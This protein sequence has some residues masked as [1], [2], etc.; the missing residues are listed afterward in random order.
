MGLASDSSWWVRL[1]TAS[2]ALPAVCESGSDNCKEMLPA[3]SALCRDETVGVVNAALSSS[4]PWV[5][6]QGFFE[7][8]RPMLLEIINDLAHPTYSIT[9]STALHRCED[10]VQVQINAE[11]QRQQ[12]KV[13]ERSARLKKEA[14]ES[15]EHASKVAE[16]KATRLADAAER[17]ENESKAAAAIAQAEKA[18]ATKAKA[19][20]EE[21]KS[22]SSKARARAQKHAEAAARAK[23]SSNEAEAVAEKAMLKAKIAEHEMMLQLDEAAKAQ[24]SLNKAELDN[25]KQTLE[26]T[27]TKLANLETKLWDGFLTFGAAALPLLAS[28]AY[29]AWK[30]YSTS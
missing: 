8:I 7:E 9:A 26:M 18:K 15:A 10:I 12:V 24:S 22:K 5:C 20:A 1:E 21:E 13:A 6:W 28:F 4:V 16:A 30:A 3:V 27:R 11:S 14:A 23:N 29:F 2:F 25:T 19:M 17:A